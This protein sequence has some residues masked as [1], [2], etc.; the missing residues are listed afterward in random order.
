MDKQTNPREKGGAAQRRG[1]GGGLA[2]AAV[3][4]ITAVLAVLWLS[5]PLIGWDPELAGWAVLL[6]VMVVVVV[7]AETVA[8]KAGRR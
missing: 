6:V 2:A 1:P 5:V 4:G 7:L 8:R 3:F